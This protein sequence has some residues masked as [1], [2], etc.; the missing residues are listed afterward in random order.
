MPDTIES[1]ERGHG[2]VIPDFK[3]SAGTGIVAGG[4]ITGNAFLAVAFPGASIRELMSLFGS[5]ANRGH[6][7]EWRSGK[8]MIPG[9]ALAILQRRFELENARSRHMLDMLQR[10][11]KPASKAGQSTRARIIEAN[12]ILD[13]H[14]D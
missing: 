9:W 11:E 3:A 7:S 8:R 4:T 10:I 13:S 12:R 14:R 5:H 2:H 1:Q 6:V